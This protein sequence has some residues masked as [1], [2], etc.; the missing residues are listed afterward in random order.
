MSQPRIFQK[1]P[2]AFLPPGPLHM[3]FLLSRPLLPQHL[4]WMMTSHA[5]GLRLAIT[6]SEKNLPFLYSLIKKSTFLSYHLFFTL[7]S[8]TPMDIHVLIQYF[9]LWPCFKLCVEGPYLCF[10]PALAWRLAQKSHFENIHW[11]ENKGMKVCYLNQ[12]ISL[13][14]ALAIMT[15]GAGPRLW[16]GGRGRQGLGLG[17]QGGPSLKPTGAAWLCLVSGSDFKAPHRKQV[18]MCRSPEVSLALG[19]PLPGFDEAPSVAGLVINCGH[20][21]CSCRCK[22]SADTLGLI[23]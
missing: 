1:M 11:K 23:Y 18:K 3:L 14:P 16:V 12:G 10:I 5:S 22:S 8:T 15:D 7:I 6:S 4:T 9:G 17:Q 13:I 2:A 20:A 21:V 19:R